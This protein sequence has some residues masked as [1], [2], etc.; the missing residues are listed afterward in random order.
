MGD[1]EEGNGMEMEELNRA[2][3][4]RAASGTSK[5]G[6]EEPDGISRLT[7]VILGCVFCISVAVIIVTSTLSTLNTDSATS[8]D[9][10]ELDE[11]L[12]SGISNKIY[13]G[14][15]AVT[16]LADGTILYANSFGTFDYLEVNPDSSAVSMDSLFDIASLSK[17]LATTTAVG[18]LY[19]RGYL[20]LNA[21]I[22]DVLGEPTYAETGGKQNVTVLNCLLHNAGYL[23]DPNPQYF[24]STFG[25][26]NTADYHPAQDLSCMD[27]IYSSLLNEVLTQPPNTLY[28]Y[29]DLSFITLH[30]VVG[31]I[32]YNNSLVPTSALR[33]NCTGYTLADKGMLYSCY[34]EA[35]VRTNAFEEAEQWVSTGYLPPTDAYDTCVPTT[36]DTTYR[37]MLNQGDVM[38]S[39]CYAMGGICGHAGIYTTAPDAGKILRRLAVLASSTDADPVAPYKEWLNV[40]TVQ[41]FAKEHNQTQ[42]SRALGWTTNDPTVKDYGFSNSCGKLSELTFMHIGYTGTCGCVDP[43]NKVWSVILTNRVYMLDGVMGNSTNTKLIYQQYHNTIV[44]LFLS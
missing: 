8:V 3:H 22:A 39:N 1:T 7:M 38:D 2:D 25:C 33:P 13:P 10:S 6:S 19:Q 43:V 15:V 28:V 5:G 27:M 37:H 4:G 20:D 42:S 9:T 44:D 24:T 29:S 32:V 31:K 11:I 18:L 30:F 40:T 12:L 21:S 16:G 26:P 23:P 17:T 41:L 34:F 14:V 35:F 36:N